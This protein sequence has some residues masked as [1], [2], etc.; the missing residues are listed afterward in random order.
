VDPLERRMRPLSGTG[1]LPYSSNWYV[2]AENL[3]LL[4]H[5]LGRTVMGLNK[6]QIVVPN[7]DA[8][9][10]PDEQEILQTHQNSPIRLDG[11]NNII[12]ES[13]RNS[14]RRSFDVTRVLDNL[15]ASGP[16]I[17]PSHIGSLE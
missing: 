4:P 10:K 15:Q 17:H 13:A 12:S 5:S 2:Y 16:R 7:I 9:L 1:I 11:I 14:E 8:I 3:K 6:A